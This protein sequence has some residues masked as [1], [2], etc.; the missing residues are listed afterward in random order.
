MRHAQV[1]HSIRVFERDR[2]AA[3]PRKHQ[4]GQFAVLAAG[5][6]NFSERL[7]AVAA[8]LSF[9]D[10][11]QLFEAQRRRLIASLFDPRIG[12]PRKRCNTQKDAGGGP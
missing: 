7:P 4:C 10:P 9:D 5:T 6:F 3:V 11:Y 8:A 12:R 2:K 1:P